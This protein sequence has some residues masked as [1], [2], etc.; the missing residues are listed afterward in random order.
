VKS[1]PSFP[2]ASLLDSVREKLCRQIESSFPKNSAAFLGCVKDG[3]IK[4]ET[5]KPKYMDAFNDLKA[6]AL[7]WSAEAS[8][9]SAQSSSPNDLPRTASMDQLASLNSNT[10]S[11]MNANFARFYNSSTLGSELQS[12]ASSSAQAQGSSGAFKIT[13]ASAASPQDL[14]SLSASDKAQLALQGLAD[15]ILAKTALSSSKMSG[16]SIDQQLSAQVLASTL[17]AKESAKAQRQFLASF[18]QFNDE[19]RLSDSLSPSLDSF[20]DLSPPDSSRGEQDFSLSEEEDSLR[21]FDAQPTQERSKRRSTP[22]G[23]DG[24]ELPPFVLPERPRYAAPK[25]SDQPPQT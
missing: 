16:N 3:F 18:D 19:S 24:L 17:A 10:R 22:P 2:T 15:S 20:E 1:T 23:Q 11:S 6:S 9:E 8:G 12:Q 5:L 14:R 25:S 4:E 21:D 7:K 13:D